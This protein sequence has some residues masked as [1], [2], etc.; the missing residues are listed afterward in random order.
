MN[1]GLSKKSPVY[2]ITGIS[3]LV[4][5]IVVGVADPSEYTWMPKCIFKLITGYDCP[6]CGSSRAL[7][8][9]IHGN[10]L[11]ALHFNYFLIVTF[12]YAGSV[13]FAGNLKWVKNSL[14]KKILCGKVVAGIYIVMFFFWWI[15]R[16]LPPIKDC[17]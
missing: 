8:A 10:F 16:N 2:W 6:G 17:L 5:I 13:F 14:I 15:I 11:Q 12:I 1:I 7:H 9:L 3:I 4:A